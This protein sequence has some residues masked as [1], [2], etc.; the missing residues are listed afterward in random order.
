MKNKVQSSSLVT[1]IALVLAFFTLLL[2]PTITPAQTTNISYTGGNPYFPLNMLSVGG[3][4][5]FFNSA[6]TNTSYGFTNGAI[7]GTNYLGTNTTYSVWTNPIASNLAFPKSRYVTFTFGGTPAITPNSVADIA[8]A[9]WDAST[10]YGDWVPFTNVVLS[11]YASGLA[12]AGTNTFTQTN[13]TADC[14]S[15][16]FFRL[17]RIVTGA[18]VYSTLTNVLSTAGGKTASPY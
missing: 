14:G 17:N 11:I 2:A 9:Y 10:G 1:S 16:V 7:A 3:S 13:L 15:L 6:A 8:T 12:T 4:G 5:V 18:T